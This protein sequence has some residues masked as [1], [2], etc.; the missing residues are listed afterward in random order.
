[1]KNRGK[2][3]VRADWDVPSLWDILDRES[4][5]LLEGKG[6]K[7]KVKCKNLLVTSQNFLSELFE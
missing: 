2:N 7:F 6:Q 3:G 5:S 1:M 4:G